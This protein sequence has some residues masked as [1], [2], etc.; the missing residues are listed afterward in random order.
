V[1]LVAAHKF[2]EHIVE[3]WDRAGAVE[4]WVEPLRREMRISRDGYELARELERYHSVSPDAQLVEILDESYSFM[5]EAYENALRDWVKFTGW[6]PRF[7]KD[8]R[9][10]YRDKPGIVNGV[11]SETSE[12]FFAP[13]EEA[14]RYRQGGGYVVSE[15]DL[16]A[17]AGEAGTAETTKTGSVHEH[18]IPEG[19]TPK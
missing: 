18:A 13:D 9:V 16:T 14:P 1:L 17:S 19:E 15:D 7:A 3:E 2:A 6:R 12:I 5:R 11:N 8:D 10:I 4:N